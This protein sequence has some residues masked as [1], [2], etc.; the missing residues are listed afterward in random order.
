[1]TRARTQA[2]PHRPETGR[3]SGPGGL[4]DDRDHLLLARLPRVVDDA[5]DR[6]E[7]RVVLAQRRA[8]AGV[9]RGADL[10]DDDRPGLHALAAVDLDAA[11]LRVRV[12]TVARR[13]LT[14]F[15]RHGSAL[16]LSR[17]DRGDLQ[18]GVGLTMAVLAAVVLAA[19]ELEDD[20]LLA[21]V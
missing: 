1:L 10:A 14:F 13:A 16:S 12:A 17:G 8:L 7:D 2:V 21:A 15:V 5:V 20:E 19:A 9:E 4:G 11:P 3:E 18:L 6:R